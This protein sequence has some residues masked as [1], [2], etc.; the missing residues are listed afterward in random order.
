MRMRQVIATRPLRTR[1][2][3]SRRD[4]L[5]S[6]GSVFAASALTGGTFATAMNGPVHAQA[7]T[8][9]PFPLSSEEV[10]NVAIGAYIYAYPLIIMELTRRISTNVA[11]A[12]HFGKGPMNQFGQLPA[13]PDATFTD[14]VRPNADTLYSLLW[15]DVSKEP[16][17]IDVPNSRGALSSIANARYVDGGVRVHGKRTTGT[18]AQWLAL[19]ATR[20]QA[21]CRGKPPSF[22]R[23]QR[24]AGPLGGHKPT[25]RLITTPYINFRLGCR[26]PHSASGA[27]PIN[28]QRKR[29]IP[30]GI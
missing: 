28:R 2:N 20:W 26:Q 16:L 8:T 18:G 4:I 27:N 30:I 19:A 11:D 6:G 21:A 23:P 15:F 7:S 24:W 22:A 14:V 13:F 9:E 5:L 12:S 29:S 10:A 3:L 1:T 17:L 25:A